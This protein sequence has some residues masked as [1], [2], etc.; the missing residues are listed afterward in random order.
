MFNSSLV[1]DKLKVDINVELQWISEM[2][3]IFIF[4]NYAISSPAPKT[5]VS[6]KGLKLFTINEV[7]LS[8]G[9]KPE[10]RSGLSFALK[11]YSLKL[12]F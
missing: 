1:V 11:L 10:F 9:L 12:K 8:F 2:A 4:S 6:A 5:K 3:N 7:N